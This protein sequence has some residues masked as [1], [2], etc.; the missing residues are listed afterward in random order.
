MMRLIKKIAILLFTTYFLL[1]NPSVYAASEFSTSYDIE[2]TVDA[3]GLTN[4]RQQITLKNI[5]ENVYATQY[6]IIIGS[7]NITEVTASDNFGEIQPEIK[8]EANSTKINLNFDKHIIGK[9]KERNVTVNYKT[10]DFATVKGKVLEVGFPLLQNSE[11]M[12]NYKVTIF[13]PNSFGNATQIIP[14]PDSENK[15]YTYSTYI[16]T[17]DELSDQDS[18]SAT[19]GTYQI[20]RF[21]L[22]Y[23]LENPNTVR[24]RTEIALPADTNYQQVI[25]NSIEPRPEQVN[26]DEDGNW[27]AQYVID[28]KAKLLVKAIGNIKLSYFPIPEFESKLTNEQILKYTQADQYWETDSEIIKAKARELV[29]AKQI[30]DYLVGNFTYNYQRLDTQTQRFGALES[31]KNPQQAICM[32]FTDT[33][34]A[35]ARAAGIPAREHN[36]YAYTENDKLRPLSLNQD[37]LHAWPEYYDSNRKQWIQIDPTWGNTTGGLNFF[38]KFD[39]DHI[40]FVR[41]GVDSSYPITAGSYKFKDSI[42]RDVEISFDEEFIMHNSLELVGNFPQ[43]SFTGIPVTGFVLAKNTGLGALYNIPLRI[44]FINQGAAAYTQDKVIPAV[45]PYGF[46]QQDVQYKSDWKSRGGKYIVEMVSQDIRQTSTIDVKPILDFKIILLIISAFLLLIFVLY[47][48][49][50]KINKNRYKPYSYISPK[51]IRR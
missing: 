44:Q 31:L 47:L 32:E 20:Y 26:I 50:K 5:Y 18:I 15:N 17:K 46:Y 23:N 43:Y 1:P 36:G 39:L 22:T 2:Y 16:F 42:T 33:F 9:D 37:I 10:P 45:P 27:L 24:G 40:S 49:N 21:T 38:D 14:E 19:F 11:V 34:I 4:T 41:H 29:S 48:R 7:T 28:P 25:Y 8:T 30:Y 51:T 13:I 3:K 6:S 12:E 35:L